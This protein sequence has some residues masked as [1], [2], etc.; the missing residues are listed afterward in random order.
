MLSLTTD[1]DGLASFILGLNQ[2]G[3]AKNAL[4]RFESLVDQI[5]I[6][7][8]KSFVKGLLDIGDQV[9][10][11]ALGFTV[12]SSNTHLARLIVWFLRRIDNLDERG[13]LLLESFQQSEGISILESILVADERRREKGDPDK[14]ISDA[15]FE[16]LKGEFVKKLDNLSENSPLELLTHTHLVSFL[17]RWKHWGDEEKVKS[18][19]IAQTGSVDGCV[20]LLKAFLSRSSSQ[21]VGDHFV[22]VTSY[23][24][25]ENIEDFADTNNIREKLNGLDE[26]SLD[27][28]AQEAIKAFKDALNRRE[29]GIG[30]DW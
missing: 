9:D 26:A 8:G 27:G 12:F 29:K 10:H 19:V 7:N 17:Y 24:R 6:E 4:A 16:M 30:D 22:K 3:I 15:F 28:D 20:K 2:R 13:K 23:I 18:W 14:L 1:S 25:L 11:E 21:T 5:P